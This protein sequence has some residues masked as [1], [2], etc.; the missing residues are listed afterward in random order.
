M[1]RGVEIHTNIYRDTQRFDIPLVS[2]KAHDSI[3]NSIDSLN[4]AKEP[5]EFVT[6]SRDGKEYRRKFICM[7]FLKTNIYDIGSVKVWD[8]RQSEKAVLTIKTKEEKDIW[9]VAYGQLKGLHKVI[10]I[11]Y[12]NGDIK[13]FDVNGAQYLWQIQVKDG[14]CSI[15]F[16]RDVL[17]VSTLSA[18]Y[19]IDII[20]GKKI[21]LPV[22]YNPPD[23]YT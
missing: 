20:T 6:G 3:I 2:Y 21:E 4:Q 22:M 8:A 1:T 16:D 14:I 17:L 18:A 9:A 12:E 7:P 11:G 19:I 15:D 23:I 5:Q 10:V 13:L